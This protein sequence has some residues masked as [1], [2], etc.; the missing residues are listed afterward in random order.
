LKEKDYIRSRAK[1]GKYFDVTPQAVFYACRRLKISLKKRY[2]I[3]KS[4]MKKKEGS[5]CPLSR[6]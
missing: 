3:T 1:I 5:K 2:P 6:K 4:E